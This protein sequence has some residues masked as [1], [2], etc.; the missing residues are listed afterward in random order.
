[1]LIK[2]FYI[3]KNKK[4]IKFFS[5]NYQQHAYAVHYLLSRNEDLKYLKK[6]LDH[7][8]DLTI[9]DVGANIGFSYLELKNHFRNSKIFC[10][11]PIKE[12]IF[13]LKKN[14]KQFNPQIINIG[15]SKIREKIKVG[16]PIN[17]DRDTGMFSKYIDSNS[18]EIETDKLDT[19]LDQFNLKKIDLI[20]IDVEGMELSTL[21]GSKKI[22]RAFGPI[23]Y[24]EINKKIIDDFKKID[25]FLKNFGY[26]IENHRKIN[27]D[28]SM[29]FDIMWIK[30]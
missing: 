3:Y 11:E 28:K 13:Y 26:N 7:K 1:M 29:K 19:I 5:P 9:I 30:D 24:L 18:I 6:R 14:L 12:N 10:I 4:I 16:T 21:Q 25:L 15:C 17:A 8:E 20:K 2:S 23:V 22:L 27:I